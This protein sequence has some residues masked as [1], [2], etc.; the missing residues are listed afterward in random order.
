MATEKKSRGR[1]SG[2]GIPFKK[3]TPKQRAVVGLMKALGSYGYTGDT[4]YIANRF[5]GNDSIIHMNMKLLA[6]VLEFIKRYDIL[7]T[8]NILEEEKKIEKGAIDL[9]KIKDV[10]GENITALT[11]EVLSKT[12]DEEQEKRRQ[13]DF[14]RYLLFAINVLRHSQNINNNND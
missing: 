12:E 5:I 4:V 14:L 1:A 6:G 11:L 2:P 13:V 3:Q 9:T 8:L 7:R 10:N